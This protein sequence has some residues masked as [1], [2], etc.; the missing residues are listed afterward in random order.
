MSKKSN[1]VILSLLAG[2]WATDGLGVG[3]GRVG[4]SRALAGENAAP[5]LQAVTTFSS[6]GDLWQLPHA[7]G[8]GGPDRLCIVPV[9]SDDLLSP[10]DGRTLCFLRVASQDLYGQSASVDL[11]SYVDGRVQLLSSPP[12]TFRS[13]SRTSRELELVLLAALCEG[14]GQ[15]KLADELLERA[16]RQL[17]RSSPTDT[18]LWSRILPEW[19]RLMYWNVILS[20]G[21]GDVPWSAVREDIGAYLT[22]F[23]DGAYAIDA[24]ELSEAVLAIVADDSAASIARTDA[25]Y[26]V[27]RL[28][29]QNGQQLVEPGTPDVFLDPRGCSPAMLLRD[30]GE[31]AIPALAAA[32]GDKRPTRTIGW[33]RSRAFSHYFLRVRDVAA[34]I[35]QRLDREL[36]LGLGIKW[37]G[38][39]DDRDAEALG[40]AVEM[41][42]AQR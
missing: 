12:E 24:R 42:W 10:V 41:W 34:Q 35:L 4:R 13:R 16:V 29:W 40:T 8:Y 27:H 3:G 25:D 7:S 11:R 9:R 22:V 30:M 23:P 32:L 17:A 37:R 36:N 26:L 20:L 31:R 21:K 1:L 19:D 14:R 33:R 38:L 5:W 2:L 15:P 39:L 6:G 18:T 28:A